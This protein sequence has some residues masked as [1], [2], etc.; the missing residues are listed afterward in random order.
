MRREED[1]AHGLQVIITGVSLAAFLFAV[2]LTFFLPANSNGLRVHLGAIRSATAE[3]LTLT[4]ADDERR[5]TGTFYGVELELLRENADRTASRLASARALPALRPQ[6][7]EAA[8]LAREA[9]RRLHV[10]GVPGAPAE[11][12]VAAQATLAAIQARA[13]QMEREL[14]P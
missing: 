5:S 14:E 10:L 12:V 13:K 11:S 1:S 9:A 3:G 2:G 4:R 6:F 7:D 8:A